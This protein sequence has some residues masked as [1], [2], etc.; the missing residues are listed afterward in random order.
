MLDK[1]KGISVHVSVHNIA[2]ARFAIE[3]V[4]QCRC[5]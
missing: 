3:K 1:K 2:P 5:H 4:S